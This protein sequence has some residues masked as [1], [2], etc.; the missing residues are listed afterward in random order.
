MKRQ[1][2]RAPSPTPTAF[3]GIS[4]YR[5][6][7]YRSVRDK[8][9]VP[10]VP[11]VDY[12]LVSRTHYDEL[13]RYLAAYLAKSL[14]NSRSTARQKLTRL[15]IQQFHELSTDVYDE[16][17]R[18]NNEKEVPFL[19]VREEFHPKRNQA[20]QKLATLPTSRFEDLSSDVYFE[21]S[22][23]YPE[24]KE[25]SSGRASDS[26]YD[27]Y[28]APDFPS[29]SPPRNANARTS[30]RVSADRPSDSGY[31]GSGSSRRPSEDR[32]R[33]SETDF[34]PPRRSEESFRRPEE[35][36]NAP[37]IG[38]ENFSASLASRRK[39]S[40]DT[41]RRSDER[42][43]DFGRRPSG[44]VS[45]SGASDSTATA[46]ANAAQ[47]TTATSGMIIPNKSTME[48]EYIEVPYGRD[49]RESGSTTIDERERGIEMHRDG[50]MGLDEPDSASDYPSTLSPRSPPAGLSGLSARLNGVDDDD[51]DP[52]GP[53]N[54]SGDDYYDKYGRSS[55]NSD[56]SAGTNS[57]ASRMMGGRASVSDDQEKIRRDYEFK[58]ATMQTQITNLQRDLGDAAESERKLKD[59]EARVR[60]MEDELSTFRRRAEEQSA[61]MRALQKELD[62]LRDVR[63]REKER[64]SRR[65]K[66]DEEELQILRERC[67]RL[68]EERENRK[69]G[70]D[71][72]IVEQLRSDME[73]L[74]TELNDLSRR[75]D[76]LMTAKD[77]D[78][79]VIRDLDNQLK[80]Y[81]RKYEQAKT[82]LRNV[83]VTSQ[84]FLQAPKFD[85][86]EDQLPVSS[87]GGVLDIHITAFLSAID[88]LLTA[89]RSNAPTRV[90]TPMKT[91]VNAVTNIIEDVR[92]FERR[93][94]RE[95]SDIDLDALRSLRE[96]ADATL[97]NLVAATKTH[98]TSSGMSPVSLLDAAASH[99]SVTIT[100]IGRT[101]CI[102]KATKAEQEQFSYSTFAPPASSA[103]NFSPSLRSVD[104]S[105]ASHQRK[106]SQASTS[107]RGR[108]SESPVSL[109]N[110][111]NDTRRRP[112]SDN[113]SSEQTNSPPPIFDQQP[114]GV[115]SD[116]SAQGD[117]FEDAWAEL[118]PYLEAQTES[119]VYAIQSV[120][121]GVRSP[122]PSPTL[123]ENLTQIITIVSSIV[124][125]CNDNLPPA[126]SQ[127]GNEILRELG[128]HANKLSE[129]QALPDVTKETR[130]IMAKSSFAIANAMKGLMKL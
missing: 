101:I 100:E 75:N 29:N 77:S 51:D 18:R 48:E 32:R 36:F 60:Q 42:E 95:R 16:L 26:G 37:R 94:Q 55:V 17:V 122:T 114:S 108:F 41:T 65:Y 120:L 57:I 80:D 97:S 19:P 81:K 116:D 115:V 105:R 31:G 40:Q 127:Q 79:V 53:G 28:P 13:G 98:A 69:G 5:N 119:I 76:E 103:N 27:D 45:I 9:A 113:S 74:L 61:A 35:T 130:Q 33:P 43:R 112:P 50:A 91:V 128:E 109:P 38:E 8:S 68:E 121:S 104:E 56:R 62:E 58:I 23:R 21:L 67:E 71:N 6:D 12:R 10:A 73:G 84:L 70:A 107:S 49:G 20:R 118:K 78:L 83:K 96:R 106:A 123:N 1:P 47:S 63:Q 110:R 92:N 111:Y 24:F 39:P 7:S 66:E 82:E 90:L 3:S 11:T 72:E 117:G 54:K 93:P 126:S 125:V 129:V 22:R 44:T 85:K 2:A 46:N 15:T 89:G 59:G 4:N 30:G 99:V 124:A 64:E 25:E 14:P 86:S 88:S 52:A 34:V 102:R 87:D